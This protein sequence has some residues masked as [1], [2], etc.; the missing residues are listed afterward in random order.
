MAPSWREQNKAI[1]NYQTAEFVA[2]FEATEFHVDVDLR[3]FDDGKWFIALDIPEA[4]W[5]TPAWSM[6]DTPW[7]DVPVHVTIGRPPPG[8]GDAEFEAA[9]AI[10]NGPCSFQLQ[11]WVSRPESTTY[12][13]MGQLA[14]FCR[15]FAE[16]GFVP[17][18]E[19]HV[20]M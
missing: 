2:N 17:R 5:I 14:E 4:K 15:H 9:R 3:K 8:V 19:W 7:E 1:R 20:S 18:G 12:L 6:E 16:L 13:P 10:V 11:K